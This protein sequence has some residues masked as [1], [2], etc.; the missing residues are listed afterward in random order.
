MQNREK[1]IKEFLVKH[2]TIKNSGK[3][4]LPLFFGFYPAI[5]TKKINLWLHKSIF[6][7]NI[8]KKYRSF[9]ANFKLKKWN[10]IL[11]AEIMKNSD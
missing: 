7:E 10:E 1:R 6:F 8:L 2:K 3:E 4:N 11:S 9:V 5:T